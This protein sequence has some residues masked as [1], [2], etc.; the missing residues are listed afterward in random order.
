MVIVFILVFLVFFGLIPALAVRQDASRMES[1]NN[2]KKIMLGIHSYYDAHQEFP[3]SM[4]R[5]ADGKPLYS[6]RVLLLPY[7]LPNVDE[8]EL[9]KE[10]HLDEPWDSPHNLNLLPKMPEVYRI[11]LQDEGPGMTHYQVFVGPGTAFD[12]PGL[13]KEDF[14]DGV[15][16]TAF[17]V[18][19]AEAVPWTKPVHLWYEPG[20]PL[21]GFYKQH[22]E[23]GLFTPRSKHFSIGKGDGSIE[24][25]LYP[26]NEEYVRSLITRNG[27]E[28]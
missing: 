27:H 26:F 6:W 23:E 19:A 14:P 28:S 25:F 17:V 10:F 2:L 7:L 15:Y 16:Q 8:T 21:P 12:R 18:E 11:P 13:T 5:D 22:T 1:I 3:P 4:M 24:G 20:K 9:F